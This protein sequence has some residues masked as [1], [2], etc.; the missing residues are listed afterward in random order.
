MHK[1]HRSDMRTETRN[2][3]S[4]QI[5]VTRG[6]FVYFGKDAVLRKI[7]KLGW[8][9]DLGCGFQIQASA[10]VF[11]DGVMDGWMGCCAASRPTCSE[12][13]KNADIR[14]WRSPLSL[15]EVLNLKCETEN[16]SVR[17]HDEEKL[18]K[19]VSCCVARL[20]SARRFGNGLFSLWN[21][22]GYKTYTN[23]LMVAWY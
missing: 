13:I 9:M 14:G 1:A 21:G 23:N 10:R 20:S 4:W 3:K 8:G 16:T 2:W 22:W 17:A 19:L 15:S 12:Q 18:C 6:D 7:N 11:R 5:G